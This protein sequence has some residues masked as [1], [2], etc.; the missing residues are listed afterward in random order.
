MYMIFSPFFVRRILDVLSIT[1]FVFYIDFKLLALYL[2]ITRS[3]I[4]KFHIFY[5]KFNVFLDS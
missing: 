4:Y 1:D 2:K 5:S 3:L